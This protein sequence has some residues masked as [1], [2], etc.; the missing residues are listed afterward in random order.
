MLCILLVVALPDGIP[1]ADPCAC[2]AWCFC[3]P[4]HSADKA[5][6]QR[7][8]VFSG[9]YVG[10]LPWLRSLYPALSKQLDLT[11]LSQAFSEACALPLVCTDT[12]SV[13]VAI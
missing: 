3:Q 13:V 9:N 10:S 5:Y 12:L 4:V 6:C 1:S 7:D 11:W 8:A 2:S